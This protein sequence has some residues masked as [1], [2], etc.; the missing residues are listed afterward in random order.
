MSSSRGRGLNGGNNEY[1]GGS[2]MDSLLLETQNDVRMEEL[3]DK[4]S[5]LHSVTLDIHGAV[6]DQ[7]RLLD[8]TDSNFN[9]FGGG[10][11]RTQSRVTGL[12]NNRQRRLTFYIVLLI[13][14]LAFVLYI[15]SFKRK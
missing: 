15:I 10:L 9:S 11:Q 5:Q 3:A 13:L 2:T 8:D 6:D 7:N 14:G 4:I 12:L 1:R